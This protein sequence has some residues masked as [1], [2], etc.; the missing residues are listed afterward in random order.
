M[1][2]IVVID[3][4]NR[5]DEEFIVRFNSRSVNIILCSGLDGAI[6]RIERIRPS[7]IVIL[8][9]PDIQSRRNMHQLNAVSGI[10]K[11]FITENDQFYAEDDESEVLIFNDDHDRLVERIIG[12]A[13]GEE[14]ETARPY[15]QKL[16][17]EMN[18]SFF[19]RHGYGEFDLND[20]KSN[21]NDQ[22]K[23]IIFSIMH[24]GKQFQRMIENYMIF[25]QLRLLYLQNPKIIPFASGITE[26]ANQIINGSLT[27]LNKISDRSKDISIDL[28][29]G[30]LDVMS[31]EFLEKI[32]VE[33]MLSLLK[34]SPK[35][36]KVFIR[37]HFRNGWLIINIKDKG[38]FFSKEQIEMI[39]NYE[40]SNTDFQ[41]QL[42]KRLGIIVARRLI[43]IHGGCLTIDS[44]SEK[45]VEF[46]ITLPATKYVLEKIRFSNN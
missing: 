39:E 3:P 18:N 37:S 32:F 41:N 22:V 20:P 14:E 5:F 44:S 6:K 10:K 33:L 43:E 28:E 24:S 23:D 31:P 30:S 13:E 45:G 15:K 29:N 2:R 42:G 8:D 17:S 19:A 16:P 21:E 46:D 9:D 4:G 7:I 27:K 25:S 12:L 34:K 26:N 36:G 35:S 1:K 38:A 11:V 40:P